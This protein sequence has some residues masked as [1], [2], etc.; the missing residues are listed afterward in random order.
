MRSLKKLLIAG[1]ASLTVAGAGFVVAPPVSAAP[2][3]Q[4]GWMPKSFGTHGNNANCRGAV[5]VSLTVPDNKRGIVR[6]TVTSQGF[7]GDGPSWQQ[8]PKCDLLFLANQTSGNSY[9][10]ETFFSA[11]FGRERGQRVSQDLR[12]GPGVALLSVWTFKRNAPVR[13]PQSVGT[14]SYVLVP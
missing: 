7:I 14:A 8:N 12:T 1:M 5:D 6:M 4:W 2:L 10:K 11:S 9:N 13:T 3:A